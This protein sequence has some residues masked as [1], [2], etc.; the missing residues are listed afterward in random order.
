MS[1]IT[2]PPQPDPRDFGNDEK[3][4]YYEALNKWEKVCK[5]LIE[6]TIKPN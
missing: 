1:E 4:M 5:M 2:L 3:M 6:S